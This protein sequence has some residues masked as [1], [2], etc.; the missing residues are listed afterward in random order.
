MD[1]RQSAVLVDSVEDEDSLSRCVIKDQGISF[2]N[3]WTCT[4]TLEKLIG[5]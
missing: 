5:I 4:D 2:R 3:V 1:S